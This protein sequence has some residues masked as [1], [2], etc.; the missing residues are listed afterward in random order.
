M[1]I[2][3][4]IEK[5]EKKYKRLIVALLIFI[6]I[7][8]VLIILSGYV[9]NEKIKVYDLTKGSI[10]FR[11]EQIVYSSTYNTKD[12]QDI[13]RI[14]EIFLKNYGGYIEN[15]ELPSLVFGNDKNINKITY[16]ELNQE[17]LCEFDEGP[18]VTLC[19]EIINNEECNKVT[20]Q[21]QNPYFYDGSKKENNVVVQLEN[22]EYHF[23]LNTG[24]NFYF[25]ILEEDK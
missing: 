13:R 25:V 19:N 5:I 18:Y 4:D 9:D 17:C 12:I 22:Q 15:G 11:K 3:K 14:E 23:K 2:A 16:R 24:Q 20:V 7:F 10:Q 1:G 8:T 6:G 21:S